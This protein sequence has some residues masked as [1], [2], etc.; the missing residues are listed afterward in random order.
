[1]RFFVFIVIVFYMI[2]SP[3]FA[4]KADELKKV[5]QQISQHKKASSELEKQA[6]KVEK[7]LKQNQKKSIKVAE[8]LKYIDYKMNDTSEELNKLT[9]EVIDKEEKFDRNK[10]KAIAVISALL[11]MDSIPMD[12]VIAASDNAQKILNT[13]ILLNSSMPYLIEKAENLQEDI[14]EISKAKR[15]LE[16][17]KDELEILKKRS[18]KKL[19][20]VEKLLAENKKLKVN[21]FEKQKKEQAEL[22]NLAKKASSLQDLLKRL[23]ARQSA[24]PKIKPKKPVRFSK[25]KG[26]LPIS[27]RVILGFNKKTK[28]DLTN[29]GWQMVGNAGGLVTAPIAG[30]VLFSGPF[31]SYDNIVVFDN[32]NGYNLLL[33]GMDKISV[34]VGDS[35]QAGE[36]IGFLKEDDPELYLELRQNGIPV[37][38]N[39]AIRL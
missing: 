11:R 28:L 19:Q 39:K 34:N 8:D 20:E 21:V 29:K 36:P 15:N 35:V 38:P 14:M 31:E 33:A 32:G 1:M 25:T 12:G 37:H 13:K 16:D 10:E 18:E 6:K 30:N 26:N 23:Q 24:K 2:S 5:E 9:K 4:Y 27:G 22:N 17:K 3:S 7:D